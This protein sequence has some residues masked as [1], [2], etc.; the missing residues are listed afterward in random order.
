MN[1]GVRVLFIDMNSFYA[2]V[3]AQDNPNYLGKPLIV[4]PVLADTSSAIAA[5]QEAKKLGIKTGTPIAEAKRIC[6]GIKI[7]QSRPSRYLEV[8]KQILSILQSKFPK[9]KPLSIDEFACYL[10][11][12]RASEQFCVELRDSIRQ[13]IYEVSGG[14]IKA[15]FGASSNVFLAKVAS[16]IIKPDGFVYFEAKDAQSKLRHLKLTDLPGIARRMNARLGSRFI[17]TIDDLYSKTPKEL[18]L[19]FGSIIGENWWSMMR[20]SLHPDYGMWYGKKLKSIG[21]SHVIPPEM[22]DIKSTQEIFKALVEKSFNRMR[23]QNL[24]PSKFHVGLSC[25]LPRRK[26]LYLESETKIFK[27]TDNFDLLRLYSHK[28]W[29]EIEKAFNEDYTPKKISVRW[30]NLCDAIDVIPP[31][32]EPDTKPEEKTVYVIPDRITFGDPKR[33]FQ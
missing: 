23:T 9:V 4:V 25:Y 12:D 1:P 3:E 14:N 33:I 29:E 16:E 6:P 30:T 21:H 26:Y 13:S 27:H 5:S 31:L 24:Y 18:K 2:S 22:R 8:H 32:F 7:V 20:G 28:E 15:S 17:Y 19:A 11:V 10:P